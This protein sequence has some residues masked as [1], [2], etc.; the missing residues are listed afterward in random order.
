M[1]TNHS[2][3]VA[4]L[5]YSCFFLLTLLG[6]AAGQS[7]YNSNSPTHFGGAANT[8]CLPSTPE[9]S[10]RTIPGGSFIYGTDYE[11]NV[12]ASGAKDEDVPCAVCRTSNTYTSIMIPGRKSCYTGWN[13]EYNGIL[14]SNH[15]SFKASSY[16]C[17]DASPEFVPGG[18][19]NKNG[20]LL[21]ATGTKC[22]SLT[23]PPYTDNMSVYCVVC[24]K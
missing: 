14:A 10:N 9:L 3:N 21:Y 6:Y 7:H 15:Y 4:P 12:F 24:S 16:I 22:G 17:V 8:L 11:E 1:V 5:K 13:R 18:K 23:C 19:D 20:N 2:I